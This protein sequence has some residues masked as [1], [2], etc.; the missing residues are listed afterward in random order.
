MTVYS[1]HNCVRQHILNHRVG[2]RIKSKM[3]V[4]TQIQTYTSYKIV[5]R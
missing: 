1:L 5:L 2:E 3:Y 4:L